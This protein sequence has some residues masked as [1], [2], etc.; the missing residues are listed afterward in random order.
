[1]VSLSDFQQRS[2]NSEFTLHLN[3][4]GQAEYHLNYLIKGINYDLYKYFFWGLFKMTQSEQNFPKIAGII[5]AAGAASR[6]GQPKLLLPWKGET[7]IHKTVRTALDAL[8][9]PVVIVTGAGAQEITNIVKELPVSIAHNPDWQT[10]QS[11]S[12]RAGI[13]A[14]PASTQAVIFLLGD[15]PFVTAD[16]IKELVKTYLQNHSVILAPFIGKQRANPVI[17]DRLIF[18]ELCQLEG[19]VGARSI[20]KKYPPEAM[21]WSDERILFDIDTPADYEKLTEKE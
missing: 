9:D 11:T 5:L 15:Q 18:D 1:M 21:P 2:K 12:V 17:F 13:Q 8:L 4:I 6:M 3:F 19:D 20:F 7:L 16:L 10:G 14:L